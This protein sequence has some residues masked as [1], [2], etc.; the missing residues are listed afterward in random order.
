METLEAIIT[1][2]KDLP[3][4][5]LWALILY[6]VYKAL[7]VG[8]IFGVIRFA[9]KK[10]LEAIKVMK[11][12]EQDN[13]HDNAIKELE[14]RNEDFKMTRAKLNSEIEGLCID[15][16]ESG[17][18][19]QFKRLT[20]DGYTYIFDQDVNYLKKLLDENLPKRVNSPEYKK[21]N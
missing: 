10:G 8:S 20:H 21:G 12:A 19:D 9:L 17:L 13:L 16:C 14:A 3:D 6:F 2:V 11:I 5:A 18:V 1:I 4:T 15:G 7:I